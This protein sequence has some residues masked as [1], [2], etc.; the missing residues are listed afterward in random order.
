[1]G[2]LHSALSGCSHARVL[3]LQGSTPAEPPATAITQSQHPAPAPQRTLLRRK[4]DGGRRGQL[5]LV[6]GAGVARRGERLAFHPLSG[7]GGRLCGLLVGRL[8]PLL[9]LLLPLLLLRLRRRRR[10]LLLG[11]LL[12]L[13]ASCGLLGCCWR[14]R[15]LPPLQADVRGAGGGGGLLRG[16]RATP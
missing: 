6:K 10:G 8:L 13:L 4:L 9:L 16:A 2:T 7:G 15:V 11:L 5:P 1:M 3:A 14:G 12:L